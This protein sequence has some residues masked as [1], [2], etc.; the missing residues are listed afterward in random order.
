MWLEVIK[1]NFINWEHTIVSYQLE[2]LPLW[3]CGYQ[4]CSIYI[5]NHPSAIDCIFVLPL[6]HNWNPNLQGDALRMQMGYK[7]VQISDT[8]KK[9]NGVELGTYISGIELMPLKKE[10]QENSLPPSAI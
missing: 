6:N 7:L 1:S 3:Y 2:I 5:F 8:N 10:V 4:I 9:I